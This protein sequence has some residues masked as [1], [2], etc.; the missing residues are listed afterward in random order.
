LPW[1]FV[2]D[3]HAR[4]AVHDAIN[5]PLVLKNVIRLV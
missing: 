4:Q 3:D 5:V 2:P 1:V